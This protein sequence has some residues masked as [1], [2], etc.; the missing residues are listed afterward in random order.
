[1]RTQR[2][3]ALTAAAAGLTMGLAVPAGAGEA[4]VG[5][6]INVNPTGGPVG[7]HVTVTGGECSDP[8][9]EMEVFVALTDPSF[10]PAATD[11]VTPDEDGNWTAEIVVPEG[12]DPDMTYFIHAVCR[13]ADDGDVEQGY[14]GVTFDVTEG[15][16]ATPT[17]QP[18]ATTPPTSE[19][20][21]TPPPP[22]TPIDEPPPVTG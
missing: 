12:V 2:I 19:P 16:P 8:V 13:F 22:A 20:G 21:T 6:P 4:P 17:T 10:E 5:P 11:L 15:T 3:V 14:T 9:V 1:M 18:P 7:T